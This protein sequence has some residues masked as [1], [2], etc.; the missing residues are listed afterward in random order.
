MSELH[1]IQRNL[2]AEW[3]GLNQCWGET[4]SK[5]RDGV[6]DRFERERWSQWEETIPH[7]LRLLDQMDHVIDEALFGVNDL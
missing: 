1:E 2:S 3:N 7:F 6:G 5:W 4:R